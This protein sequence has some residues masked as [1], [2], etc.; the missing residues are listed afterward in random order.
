M[1]G[2]NAYFVKRSR[3]NVKLPTQ[4]ILGNR[5]QAPSINRCPMP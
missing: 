4:V 5:I 3:E 2:L 1:T